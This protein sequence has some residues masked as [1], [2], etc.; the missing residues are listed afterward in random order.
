MVKVDV[1][2]GDLILTSNIDH[3]LAFLKVVPISR[4]NYL[5]WTLVVLPNQR[6]SSNL[7]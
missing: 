7:I 6:Y 4:A 1:I 2:V 5:H 3:D